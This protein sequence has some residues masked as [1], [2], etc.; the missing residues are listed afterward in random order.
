M[1]TVTL[2]I[3]VFF[4]CFLEFCVRIFGNEALSEIKSRYTKESHNSGVMASKFIRSIHYISTNKQYLIN[5]EFYIGVKKYANEAEV[6]K[7]F[8]NKL[9]NDNTVLIK[10]APFY[11]SLNYIKDYGIIFLGFRFF[12]IIISYSIIIIFIKTIL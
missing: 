9:S 11:P 1:F 12:I 10:Y 4:N 2:V 6:D 8:L 5:Y 7:D 3:T